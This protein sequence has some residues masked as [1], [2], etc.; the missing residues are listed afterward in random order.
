MIRKPV[1]TLSE[2]GWVTSTEERAD[3][4]FSHFFVS[5]FSQTSLYVGNVASFPHI[6]QN[7]QGN[8]LETVTQLKQILTL[9]FS[10]YFSKVIV[11]ANYVED[12]PKSGQVRINLYV[13]FT[14]E[15]G[16]EFVLSRVAELMNSKI[17][18]IL[19]INNEE[20]A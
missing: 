19:T 17:T 11:E 2:D 15:T 6:I 14:D 18:N 1:P 13:S 10:R 20:A 7:N 12:P 16:K 3:Y 8:M 9:Y 5:E 4:L